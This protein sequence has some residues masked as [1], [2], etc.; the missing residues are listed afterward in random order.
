MC[1][2]PVASEL[3][4]WGTLHFIS[5]SINGQAYKTGIRTVSM[6]WKIPCNRHTREQK[7]EA[8]ESDTRSY[9]GIST[10]SEAVEGFGQGISMHD[11]CQCLGALHM[12][13]L[14]WST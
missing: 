3:L 9:T 7:G 6:P 12:V 8:L 4:Q 14:V 1:E 2:L 13:C 11:M 5:G 10:T